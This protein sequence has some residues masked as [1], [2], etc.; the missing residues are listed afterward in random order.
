MLSRG[1]LATAILAV[2]FAACDEGT[3]VSPVGSILR[4][5]A[6]PTRIGATGTST[7]TIQALRGQRQPGQRGTEIR[8]STTIG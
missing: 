6:Q 1:F 5:S 3:P 2:A 8:L 7:V 4:I